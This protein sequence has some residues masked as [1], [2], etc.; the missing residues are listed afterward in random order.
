MR[1]D[2]VKPATTSGDGHVGKPFRTMDTHQ[3]IRTPGP[4]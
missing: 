4:Q 2:F 3:R 1:N